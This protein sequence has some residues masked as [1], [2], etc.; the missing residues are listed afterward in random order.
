MARAIK[1]PVSMLYTLGTTINVCA[2]M[3]AEYYVLFVVS[4]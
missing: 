3:K 2:D 4:S 1:L